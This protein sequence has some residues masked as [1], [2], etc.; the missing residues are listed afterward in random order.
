MAKLVPFSNRFDFLAG[1]RFDASELTNKIHKNDKND[2]AN[3]VSFDLVSINFP[4]D[5]ML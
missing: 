2:D 3:F 4:L 5:I 1:T